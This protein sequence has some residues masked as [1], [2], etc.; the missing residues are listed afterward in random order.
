MK[1]KDT[2]TIISEMRKVSEIAIQAAGEGAQIDLAKLTV[3]IDSWR[4]GL[5]KTSADEAVTKPCG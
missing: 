5:E 2:Q 4:F 1:H 3:L